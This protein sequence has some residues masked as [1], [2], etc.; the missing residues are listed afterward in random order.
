M[1]EEGAKKKPTKRK[2]RRTK[3][4]DA[5]MREQEKQLTD[6]TAN[7]RKK[8][9]AAKDVYRA[10][11]YDLMY[12]DGICQVEEGLFSQTIAFDDISYQSAREENQQAIFSGWCQL[13]DYFGAE[14]CV[15][16]NVV[17]TPI[18]AS[19][20]GSKAFF[21]VDDP[22]TAVYAAEYNRILNDKMREGV[23]NLV[24][25][26]Y[27]TFSVG[28]PDVD[29][30]V[31]KLARMRTD[32]MQTLTKIRSGAHVLT[33]EERLRSIHSQLRPGKPSPPV[34]HGRDASA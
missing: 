5:R 14:T 34:S 13:F 30:A 17:N 33:G 18:P 11:G 10:I 7:Q 2:V 21:R 29:S 19:E 27:L 26:R 6:Q 32:A 15:Q 4:L 23:S 24:C 9:R 3:S 1:A 16:L 20:I 12:R 8:R 31:P 28:A 25:E 22:D